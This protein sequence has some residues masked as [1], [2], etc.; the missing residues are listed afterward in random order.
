M[1]RLALFSLAA[2]VLAACQ[3]EGQA[4]PTDLQDLPGDASAVPFEQIDQL[5][6]PIGGPPEAA[7][8]EIRDETTWVEFWTD[9]TRLLVPPPDPPAIDFGENMVL[10]AAMG[11]RP[12]AGYLISIEGVYESGGNLFVDVRE[13]SPGAGCLVAQM[14]TAPVTAVLVPVHDGS[15]EFLERKETIDCG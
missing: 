2:L 7:R 5:T 15:V 14:L 9:V 4:V 13:V 3:D 10:V 11:H 8:R 1:K 12:T 6:S